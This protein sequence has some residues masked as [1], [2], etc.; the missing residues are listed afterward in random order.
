MKK[1]KIWLMIL[2]F[3]ALLS[4]VFPFVKEGLLVSGKQEKQSMSTELDELLQSNPAIDGGLLGLSVRSAA[5]GELLYDHMGNIRLRP[6]SNMKLLTAATA[7]SV[8][9]EDYTFTTKVLTDGKIEENKLEGN[10]Y[11]KGG[12]DP[13]LL[14]SD[15]R[16]FAKKLRQAGV[17]TIHGN[18]VGDDTWYDSVRY[19]QDMIWSDEDTYYGAQISALTASPNKDYDAGTVIIKVNPGNKSGEKGV[20]KVS[21]NTNYINVE[22]NTKTVDG[23]GIENLSF[24]RK[25]GTNTIVLDGT[26]PLDS[27]TV[28]EW[29]PVWEPTG[30]ALDLFTRALDKQ[31][32]TWTGRTVQSLTP[33]DTKEL[34]SHSSMPL[35]E[36][37]IPLMKL[38]N[39]GIAETLLKEMAKVKTGEG[40]FDKGLAI[41]E[42]QLIEYGVDPETLLIRDGSGISH[43]NLLPANELSRLLY[44][45]QNEKWF[46]SF[47]KALP[48][49]S[50]KDRMVGGTLRY[51]M[52]GLPVQAKTG[53]LT[54]VSALSGYVKASND[55]NIVFSILINNVLDEEKAKQ[56]EDAIVKILAK[57]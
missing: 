39:N 11:L 1:F 24:N 7:L 9:G 47:L 16:E 17:K 49:A 4:A 38:S 3:C 14:V 2:S 44:A 43:I 51:R 33:N 54:S 30:Y 37:L 42:E 27:E 12:G 6:A 35:K 55:Q 45:I 10:L 40:S 18:V 56:L 32:I 48:V 36:L 19:S 52:D 57:T 31:G 53:S 50:R 20:I 41:L 46:P 23:E 22:N 21:P 34:I 5:S 15:F 29:M 28:K 13:T 25:H 26:I 8:L